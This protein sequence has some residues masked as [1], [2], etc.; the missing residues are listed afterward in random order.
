M[1]G[2]IIGGIVAAV[3]IVGVFIAAYHLATGPET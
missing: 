2:I 1:T 3:S